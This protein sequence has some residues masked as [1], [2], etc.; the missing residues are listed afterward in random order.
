MRTQAA[1]ESS[2][3]TV[4]QLVAPP[5]QKVHSGGS[6]GGRPVRGPVRGR[7]A[8]YT[9]NKRQLGQCS[10]RRDPS[11]FWKLAVISQIEQLGSDPS[12]IASHARRKVES[13]SGFPWRV[14]FQ[15]VRKKSQIQSICSK[16][17]LGKWGPRPFGSSLPLM[18]K[19]TQSQGARI[20]SERVASYQHDV[21][22]SLRQWFESERSYGHEISRSMLRDFYIKFLERQ[23]AVNKAKLL[24]LSKESGSVLV[25][26]QPLRDEVQR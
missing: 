11:A 2:G 25:Q 6:R 24:Q 12:T 14:L 18:K 10:L 5:L 17:K 4:G 21:F 8:G 7:A 20:Q 3:S 1:L 23:F 9:S 13:D 22:K 15:W 26:L 19:G 16:L